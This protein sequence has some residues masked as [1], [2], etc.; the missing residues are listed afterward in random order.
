MLNGSQV[1]PDITFPAAPIFRPYKLS[2]THALLKTV[3]ENSDTAGSSD[4]L[5]YYNHLV[6]RAAPYATAGPPS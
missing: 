2:I 6:E 4:C 1:S 5:D 3:E